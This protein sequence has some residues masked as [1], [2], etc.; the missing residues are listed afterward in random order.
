MI[1]TFAWPS[2][3]W[4]AGGVTA[5][6]C[7][8]N[9]LARRGHEVHFVHGPAW[10]DLITSMDQLAWFP[11]DARVRHHILPDFD[12]AS[13]PHADIVFAPDMPGDALPCI[14]I[15]G[16][17]MLPLELERRAFTTPCPKVCIASWLVGVGRDFGVPE[18]QL[19]H[20]PMGLDHELFSVRVPPDDRR[21]DVGLWHNPHPSKGGSTGWRALVEAQRRR[22]D[23]R[24]VIFS[25]T[26]LPDGLA[27]QADALPW[28]DVRLGLDQQG[29]A[30]Q[31]FNQTRIFLQSS[32][33]EGFGYTAVEAMACGAA[34]VSTDNGGS[35]D[36]AIHEETAIVVPPMDIEG[37]AAGIVELMSDDGGR[38]RLAA[39]GERHVRRFDWDLGAEI[40]EGHLERYLA[41]PEAFRAPSADLTEA[42]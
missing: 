41:D 37:L 18:E 17:R 4:R 38:A 10:P 42:Q 26:P 33:H 7:F 14:F 30:D 29:L 9:G 12:E 2:S 31:V 15:Q 28:V 5:L 13:L 24:A 11:F 34:L 21:Y 22:P 20:V 23:L 39:A 16:F 25:A 3:H 6:Y 32:V 40:L 35:R 19:W 27:R 36:Y 1:V 8:A